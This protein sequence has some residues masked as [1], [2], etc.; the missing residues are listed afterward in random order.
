MLKRLCA[1]ALFAATLAPTTAGAQTFM[2]GGFENPAPPP[3]GYQLY[4]VGSNIGGFTTFGFP[5][6]NVAV[7]SNTFSDNTGTNNARSGNA[8]IDLTGS[9]DTNQFQGVTQTLSTV[10]GQAYTLSF[11]LG[12]RNDQLASVL[13]VSTTGINGAYTDFTNAIMTGTPGVG[14]IAYQ[15]FS[16]NFVATGTSTEFAFRNDGL[17]GGSLRSVALDDISI[18]PAVAAVPGPVAG[19]GL[20]PLFGLAGAWY[21][22]RRKQRAA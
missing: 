3:G 17:V 21:A 4:G 11:Y 14:S 13:G 12:N 22:R 5:S 19:A 20:I 8:F 1:A 10:A 7:I 18:A 6:S 9:V 2:N 15:M 16:L